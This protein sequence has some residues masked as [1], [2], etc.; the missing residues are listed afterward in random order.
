MLQF[1]KPK[2]KLRLRKPLKRS[3]KRI[4]ARAKFKAH[5]ADPTKTYHRKRTDYEVMAHAEAKR[6]DRLRNRTAGELMFADILRALNVWF[7]PEKIFQNG[8]A[9]IIADFFLPAHRIAVE[10]DGSSHD[11]K[12]GYDAGRDKWLLERHGVRTIRVANAEVLRHPLA[13][14]DLIGKSLNLEGRGSDR[15]HQVVRAASAYARQLTAP[16]S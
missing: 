2:R 9:Y 6:Q 4:K 13:I 15:D 14:K 5:G 1:P 12:G 7:V 10:V 3:R 16:R 11:D 8:D